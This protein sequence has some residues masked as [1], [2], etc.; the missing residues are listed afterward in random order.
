MPSEKE[1]W[2]VPP[3]S[4]RIAHPQKIYLK[5]PNS[6]RYVEEYLVD[7]SMTGMFVRCLNP[8]PPGTSF[9]FRMRLVS[10][11]DNVE[12]KASVVWVRNEQQRLTHPKGMGVRFLE[13]SASSRQQI[14]ETVERYAQGPE[15]PPEMHKLRSVVEETLGDVLG[16]EIREATG[17]WREMRRPTPPEAAP[18]AELPKPVKRPVPAGKPAAPRG[19][20]FEE[21]RAASIP[22]RR[23]PWIPLLLVLGFLALLL[24]GIVFR[25]RL[26][27]GGA[28]PARESPLD[29]DP[30]PLP[31]E[32]DGAAEGPSGESSGAQDPPPG[33][34][35]GAAAGD[36]DAVEPPSASQE[37]VLRGHV[38]AWALA[39]STKDVDAYLDFYAR[40]FSPS[41]GLSGPQWRRQR[42]DRITKP[43]F[44]NVEVR[45][46]QVISSGSGTAQT[47]FVQEYRSE[48]LKNSVSKILVWRR[49][50][51]EWKISAERVA[52]R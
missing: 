10:G 18:L 38:H 8:A 28:S 13:L 52:N 19:P 49:Y 6:D 51:G 45:N 33:D 47:R 44:I 7:L 40:D 36:G 37:Q 20:A 26:A 2:N 43:R 1:Q 32:A 16:P 21:G 14:R 42:R 4:R 17:Q 9:D 27:G 22:E 11:G 3:E 35:P 29:Q 24:L 46:L 30:S 41:R 5:F 12:G 34:G 15:T 31:G 50:G 23:I 25:D 48:S 39:W